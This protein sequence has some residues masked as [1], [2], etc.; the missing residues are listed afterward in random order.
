[1]PRYEVRLARITSYSEYAWVEVEA[2]DEY[3]ARALALEQEEDDLGWR[4][5]ESWVPEGGDTYTEECE[6][7]KDE[8][9]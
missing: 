7:V 6:E 2:D 1:M 3:H 4:T 8:H 9:S 5:R